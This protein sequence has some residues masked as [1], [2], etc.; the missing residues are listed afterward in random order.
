[1]GFL[2]LNGEFV[3][4]PVRHLLIGG[5]W[6]TLVIDYFAVASTDSNIQCYLGMVFDSSSYIDAVMKTLVILVIIG[7]NL[8]V[9]AVLK[10]NILTSTNTI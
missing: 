5:K 7:I 2:V 6:E 3:H 9:A 1:M 4:I 8:S 10:M